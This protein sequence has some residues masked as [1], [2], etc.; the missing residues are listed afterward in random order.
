M[1]AARPMMVV[2]ALVSLAILGLAVL[3]I[4]AWNLES[5]IVECPLQTEQ[6]G[7]RIQLE[8]EVLRVQEINDKVTIITLANCEDD[9]A[10]FGKEPLGIIPHAI[11]RIQG[12]VVVSE[13]GIQMTLAR[14]QD[15][16]SFERG[17]GRFTVAEL[18]DSPASFKMADGIQVLGEVRSDLTT[19]WLHDLED[20]DLRLEITGPGA[21]AWWIV[22][23]NGSLEFDP[24]SQSY[25]LE[26]Q[27]TVEITVD[28]LYEF[29]TSFTGH[30][31]QVLGR[32]QG[33]PP[34]LHGE[35]HILALLAP[36]LAEEGEV[37][38][39]GVLD[40]GEG[41]EL[42]LIPFL[43]S[44]FTVGEL[45]ARP[46][47]FLGIS[48][49]LRGDLEWSMPAYTLYDLLDPGSSLPLG[50]VDCWLGQGPL[51]MF[52]SLQFI[53]ASDRWVLLGIE[54]AN[55]TIGYLSFP[56]FFAEVE[57]SPIDVYGWVINDENGSHVFDVTFG[58]SEREG[59]LGSV[60]LDDWVSLPLQGSH[61]TDGPM[62][63]RVLPTSVEGDSV[64]TL[65]DP[66]TDQ[67]LG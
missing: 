54:P 23:Q 59:C 31:I 2:L 28:D 25:V 4:Y 45:L 30:E 62:L 33:G 50:L 29:N 63:L 42:L 32:Y 57:G 35:E 36:L 9:I 47:A 49:A 13:F 22:W 6:A 3:F 24:D 53:S 41:N 64:L 18:L 55:Y 56:E 21:E 58:D 34:E 65:L 60:T 8:G 52:G 16:L 14:P 66:I 17:Q 15:I 44:E 48:I 61:V 46:E 7:M 1:V 12:T 27:G 43:E 19:D 37:T 26:T 5:T 20:P 11:V 10:Y 38:V 51:S 39:I 67:P 40:Q